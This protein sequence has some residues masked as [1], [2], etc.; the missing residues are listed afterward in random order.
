MTEFLAFGQD[1]LQVPI[2][3]PS[4]GS[5]V[6]TEEATMSGAPLYAWPD[7]GSTVMRT[8]TSDTEYWIIGDYGDDW[9][10]VS[11]SFYCGQTGYM[12]K[13]WFYDGSG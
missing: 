4:R 10:I 11:S 2:Y 9:Y 8:F 5:K 13:K 7:T 12:E 1:M 6:L 3:F